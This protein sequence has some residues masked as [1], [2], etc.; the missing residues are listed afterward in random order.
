MITVENEFAFIPMFAPAGASG[1]GLF[2][3]EG[4]LI[5]IVQSTYDTA[6]GIEIPG[7]LYSARQ[8]GSLFVKALTNSRHDPVFSRVLVCARVL[9]MYNSNPAT[10]ENIRETEVQQGASVRTDN[11]EDLIR[12]DSSSN[13]TP[14]SKNAA[15][16]RTAK[17]IRNG[18][19]VEIFSV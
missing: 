9:E 3:Q 15:R 8:L 2:T 4:R 16:E 14:D 1:C 18:E 12:N 11:T 6:D 17:V 5:G 13:S 10:I 7:D 19:V